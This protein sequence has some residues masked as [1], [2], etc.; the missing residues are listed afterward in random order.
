VTIQSLFAYIDAV[1]KTDIGSKRRENQDAFRVIR[2]DELQMFLLADGMG[3]ARGGALAS[4]KTV[5]I[6]SDEIRKLK[7]TPN[8]EN[9]LESVQRA[10]SLINQSARQDIKLRGMGTTLVGLLFSTQRVILLNVGDSRCYRLR[11]KRLTQLSRDHTVWQDISE[12]NDA[13][14]SQSISAN[15]SHMLTRS[16]GPESNV[17]VDIRNLGVEAGDT[18]LLC[19]DGLYNMVSEDEIKDALLS[20][21][22]GKA[23]D[24]L[25]NRANRNGGLDNITAVI[26]KIKESAR[27]VFPFYDDSKENPNI[28]PPPKNVSF[29]NDGFDNEGGESIDNNT[30]YYSNKLLG[31]IN[32]QDLLTRCWRFLGPALGFTVV[33]MALGALL[34]RP[35][36]IK[37]MPDSNSKKSEKAE[38]ATRKNKLKNSDKNLQSVYRSSKNA[39]TTLLKDVEESKLD[40]AENSFFPIYENETKAPTNLTNIGK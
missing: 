17:E 9:V 36:D 40:F 15:I 12:S 7:C 23:V 34:S 1:A 20:N 22:L 14:L 31:D 13:D 26:V 4:S 11:G 33:G 2:T 30:S 10:N 5:E 39:L 6:V 37:N 27:S 35:Q 28:K 32:R 8:V 18:Y 21:S 3:G 38:I 19:S 24:E 29:A 16:V 25:V